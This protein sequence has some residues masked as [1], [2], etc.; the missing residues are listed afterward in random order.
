MA[1]FEVRVSE[2]RHYHQTR[3]SIGT[4]IDVIAST[5]SG[6]TATPGE[7]RTI[8]G[9]EIQDAWSKNELREP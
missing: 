7:I 6:S 5:I 1:I 3:T 8:T 4:A 9:Q 2:I